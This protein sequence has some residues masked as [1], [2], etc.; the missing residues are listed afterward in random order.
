MNEQILNH[1]PPHS[2]ETA[3]E[4]FWQKVEKTP[5]CW[6]WTGSHMRTG[7]G[8]FWFDGRMMPAYRFAY[9]AFVGSIPEGLDVDHLC[10]E[11]RC[12]RPDHLEPV[13]KRENGLRW[14]A[15]IS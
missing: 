4:R 1:R 9:R 12:V 14:W 10:N 8:L 11:P 13:T 6:L 15:S 5:T 3:G 7:H 2:G